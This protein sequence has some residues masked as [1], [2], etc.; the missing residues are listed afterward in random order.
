MLG[1]STSRRK[2]E[3]LTARLDSRLGVT[4]A[5]EGGIL[6]KD[7]KG[8]K[9]KRGELN[10]CSLIFTVKAGGSGERKETKIPQTNKVRACDRKSCH[11]CGVSRLLL[12]NA[13]SSGCQKKGFGT[14]NGTSKVIAGSGCY[15][16]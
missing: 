7:D 16:S 3:C 15:I 5:P 12:A 14:D 4:R 9:K 13:G 6:G 10:G 1:Q 2:K 11:S 8:K